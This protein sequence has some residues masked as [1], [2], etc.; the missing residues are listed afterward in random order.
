[1]AD[2]QPELERPCDLDQS[3]LNDVADLHVLIAG[4]WERRRRPA[5]EIGQSSKLAGTRDGPCGL[6]LHPVNPKICGGQ[7]VK[8]MEKING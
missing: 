8:D 5:A 3:L 6:D 2:S 4:G 7:A 1:M